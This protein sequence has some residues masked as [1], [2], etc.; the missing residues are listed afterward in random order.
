MPHLLLVEEVAQRRH[1]EAVAGMQPHGRLGLL[2][3]LL[4]L[5]LQ[6]GGQAVQR[7]RQPRAD[8]LAGPH[9]LLRQRRQRAAATAGL[10]DQR[11]AEQ[12]LGIA[13]DAPGV[14]VRQR[15]RLRRVTD[16]ARFL[17]MAQQGDQPRHVEGSGVGG[18]VVAD[19]QVGEDRD[20]KHMKK[21]AY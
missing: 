15:H 6:L 11:A 18:A 8:A 9:Q 1:R 21:I 17:D 20:T 16:A 14:A 2:H 19:L 5:D 13:Q 7:R 4:Q 3:Q 10:V 12:G